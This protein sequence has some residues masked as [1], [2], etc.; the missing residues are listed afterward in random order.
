MHIS[1]SSIVMLIGEIVR[2]RI[3]QHVDEISILVLFF[4]PLRI[5]LYLCHS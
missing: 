3:E 5:F 2:G 4:T 1:L